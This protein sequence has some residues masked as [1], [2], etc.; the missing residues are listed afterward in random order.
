[1]R[2]EMCK[3]IEWLLESGY[4][5]AYIEYIEG[6]EPECMTYS[7]VIDVLDEYLVGDST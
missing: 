5:I 6:E 4:A 3:F 1:M 7:Q 2:T